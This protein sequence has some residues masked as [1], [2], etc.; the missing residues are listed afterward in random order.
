MASLA[1][2]TRPCILVVDDD[3]AVREAVS[4]G[5][6]ESYTVYAAASGAEACACLSSHGIAVI[7]LD[8]D[9]GDEHGLDLLPRFR[10]LSWARILVLGGRSTEVLASQALRAGLDGYLRKPL[11]L[12]ELRAA[13]DRLVAPPPWSSPL[14]AR[15]RTRVGNR[16]SYFDVH[17][18]EG[19]PS[20]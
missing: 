5:L 7:V 20:R 18:N 19:N 3:P 1:S 12:A 11:G 10:A 13:V 6:A 8:V 16:P 17:T 15:V 4:Y 14:A 2:T 9:L